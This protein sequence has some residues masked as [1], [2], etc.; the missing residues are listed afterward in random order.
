MSWEEWFKRRRP[1]TS[2]FQEIEEMIRE[3]ER[4]MERMF[5]RSMK[6]FE[7][8]VPKELVREYKLP[9]GSVR[10]EWGPFV[11][12][13]SI[14][15]G[16]DGKPI[17]R[18]FGNVRP[19]I[20]GGRFSLKEEREPFVDVL[21]TDNEVKVIVELPGVNKEDIKLTATEKS[22][23]INAQSPDRKYSKR[24]ELPEEVDPSSAKSTYKNGILEVTFKKK[25]SRQ[26]GF[27]IKID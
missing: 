16:P 11:Y 18:E 3:M 1:F 17:I 19:S 9:D 26:E 6:E 8:M 7:E 15:I 13:Y 12:G 14:T 4:E 5:E 20:T 21:T 24:V 23:S 25:E 27:T 10:R 22:L 2:W